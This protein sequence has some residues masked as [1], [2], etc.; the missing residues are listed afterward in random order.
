MKCVIVIDSNLPLGLIANTSAIMGISL[1]E[2]Y[3]E[4]VGSDVVDYTGKKHLG[5]IKIPVPILKADINLIKNIRNKLYDK[6]FDDVVCVD[7]SDIAQ[8]CK[9]YEEFIEKMN[10][11]PN[12]D[13]N[14][15]GICICGKDK[16][17][18]KLTGNLPLLR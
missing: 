3:P 7:F 13:L 9:T 10:H 5:I 14:Y 15:L 1:G 16:K 6:N 12:E 18:N 8:S 17:I 2:K 11:I 4:I